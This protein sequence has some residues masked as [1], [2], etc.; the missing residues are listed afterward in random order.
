M[1]TIT[2]AAEAIAATIA[3]EAGEGV[4]VTTDPTKARTGALRGAGAILVGPPI[5]T[6]GGVLAGGIDAVWTITCQTRAGASI[7][8]AW[9]RLDA[10][11]DVVLASGVPVVRAVPASVTD[12]TGT[13]SL[14]AYVLTTDPTVI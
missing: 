2:A 11:M 10:L 14:P 13:E 3:T 6:L 9:D 7:R 12:P 4:T 8:E 1:A 5:L